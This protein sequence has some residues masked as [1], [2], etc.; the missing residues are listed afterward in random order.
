MARPNLNAYIARV[1]GDYIDV[2]G[3]FG[4]QCWD[5]WSHYASSFL[6]VPSWPTYTNAGGTGPHQGYACNVYHHARTS[7]L[8]KWFDILGPGV[9]PRAGDVAFWDYGSAWYPWS[10][11]ATVLSVP[12]PGMIRCLTQNPG[13]V[14][15]SDLVTRGLIGYLRP[16]ALAPVSIDAPRSPARPASTKRKQHS[17]FM[18]YYAHALG[19][20]KQGWLVVG[21]P[22]PEVLESQQKANALARVIGNAI[23]EETESGWKKWCRMAGYRRVEVKA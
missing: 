14:Q 13:A 23:V 10:H 18:V 2:D 5:Q 12:R 1:S 6:G 7:G 4:A 16:K 15:I 19:K 17:M 3:V 20:G 21:V 11:V 22:N 9:T 8:T